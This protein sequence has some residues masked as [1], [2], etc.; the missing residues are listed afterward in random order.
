MIIQRII[1][2]FKDS[3]F[4][5]ANDSLIDIAEVELGRVL[6]MLDDSIDR[7]K[8]M[9]LGRIYQYYVDEEISWNEF[10]DFSEI[11]RRIFLSDIDWLKR[12]YAMANGRKGFLLESLIY[13]T[14][15]LSSIGLVCLVNSP[16]INGIQL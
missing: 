8:S 4:P 15:R 5:A 12:I 3:I 6:V 7:E 16:N 13:S 14:D 2:S 1:P 9:M 10:C 11:V